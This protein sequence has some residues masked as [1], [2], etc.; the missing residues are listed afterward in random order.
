MILDGLEEA[1]VQSLIKQERSTIS[2]LRR[3]KA[4][5]DGHRP[6]YSV[7]DAIDREIKECE[8]SIESFEQFLN[9]IKKFK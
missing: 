4:I 5:F 1:R 3:A 7:I 8:E 9:D 2:T 6:V